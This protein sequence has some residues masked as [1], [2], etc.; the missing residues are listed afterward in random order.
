MKRSTD[1]R[2]DAVPMKDP[3][4]VRNVD[5]FVGAMKLIATHYSQGKDIHGA[6]KTI[7]HMP[8]EGD[9]NPSRPVPVAP[10]TGDGKKRVDTFLAEI[11]E[12]EKMATGDPRKHL[13]AVALLDSLLDSGSTDFKGMM[14][15][16][17]LI[18][19]AMNFRG[20]EIRDTRYV[21]GGEYDRGHME[22]LGVNAMKTVK[23]GV[24]C[25]RQSL[26]TKDGV[27]FT[28]SKN[29]YDKKISLPN[30]FRA[31]A[32][33]LSS[34]FGGGKKAE[35]VEKVDASVSSSGPPKSQQ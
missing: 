30:I 2:D 15:D 33:A 11:R 1:E 3:N 13:A 16:G 7:V 14:C 10:P 19:P 34:F 35:P 29:E 8:S 27:D 18:S 32:N 20:H 25:Y 23:S 31:A 4:I 28:H 22:D 6:I 9:P 12:L 26:P 24:N 21:V 17:L 5:H